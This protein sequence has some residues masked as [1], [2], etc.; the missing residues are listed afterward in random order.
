MG[1]SRSVIDRQVGALNAKR[2]PAPVR[3][4]P[5]QQPAPQ[6][7]MAPQP[8]RRLSYPGGDS[9]AH[10]WGAVAPGAQASPALDSYAMGES[11]PS[12]M[13]AALAPRPNIDP[14]RTP[15]QA[16]GIRPPAPMGAGG[17]RRLSPGVYQGPDGQIIRS[18]QNPARRN[19][20]M[21]AARQGLR[22]LER[23][24]RGR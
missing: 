20:A 11:G 21:D 8:P 6:Q 22:D 14:G 18:A 23:F 19:S 7:P 13:A 15:S 24:P 4:Q 1:I 10:G 16:G 5:P 9:G 2:P 3:P 12:P 17:M